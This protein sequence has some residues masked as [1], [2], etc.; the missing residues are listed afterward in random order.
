[1]VSEHCGVRLVTR[2]GG[3]DGQRAAMKRPLA[4]G[5]DRFLDRQPRELVSKRDASVRGGDDPRCRALGEMLDL[6]GRELIQK[7]ELTATWDHR[8]RVEQGPPSV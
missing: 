3:E 8:D 5:R 1:M 4:V 7:P 6:L 2:P